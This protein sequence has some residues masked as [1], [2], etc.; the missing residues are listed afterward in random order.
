MQKTAALLVVPL[1]LLA[2]SPLRAIWVDGG[3]ETRNVPVSRLAANLEKQL[4]RSPRSAE[5][6]VNLG[7]LY[8]I[9]FIRNADV[10][11]AHVAPS[12][13]ERLDIGRGEHVLEFGAATKVTPDNARRASYLSKALEHYAA[14]VSLDPGSLY[15]RLGHGWLLEKS[16]RKAEA[17]AEYRKVIEQ[18]WPKEQRAELDMFKNGYTEEAIGYLLPLLDTT[19]DKT[20]ID[21]LQRIQAKAA[22]RMRAVT[23]LVIPLQRGMKPDHVMDTTATVRF[24][25]DGSGFQHEW[26]WIS[27]DSG[28]LVYDREG[29]GRITSA[30]QWFGNVTFW[31]FW[32]NGYEALSALDD[33]AD[34]Q[35]RGTE[36]EHIAIW[37]DANSNGKSDGGEV[38]PLAQYGIQSLSCRYSRGDGVQLAAW[39]PSGVTFTD[40]RTDATYDVILERTRSMTLTRAGGP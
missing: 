33:D 30:L 6:H 18:A 29:T 11:L 37:R 25:A 13:E 17:A 32:Q 19:R 8:A 26:T 7:R 40:G 31:L 34:G 28:W 12:G 36:L 3:A 9:A 16:G 10:L 27:P 14:A 39:S 35:L 5:I 4:Q 21:R 1:G 22:R 38:R 2:T 24:D 23:P 20:E 15:A